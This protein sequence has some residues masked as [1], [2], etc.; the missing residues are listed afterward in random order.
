MRSVQSRSWTPSRPASL[1]AGLHRRE[2]REQRVEQRV[3]DAL[4][5]LEQ[6]DPGVAVA[7]GGPRRG[8]SPCAR[9][10]GGAPR[11]RSASGLS[12][13]ATTA[14]ACTQWSPCCSSS[15][16]GQHGGCGGERVERAVHVVHVALDAPLGLHGATDLAGGLEHEDVPAGVGQG[17]GG[18]QPVG[19]GPDDD[20]VRDLL[21]HAPIVPHGAAPMHR[22]VRS[23]R[24]SPATGAGTGLCRRGRA[25]RP[26]RGGSPSAGG[27]PRRAP[28]AR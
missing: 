22:P 25:P 4:P 14:G 9:R 8:P 20:G 5:V 11:A 13:W 12:R 19:A 27:A 1:R 26:R 28:P 21:L 7:R 3:A 24:Q 17:A 18:D 15:S 10:R 23:D 16:R 2:R 6:P